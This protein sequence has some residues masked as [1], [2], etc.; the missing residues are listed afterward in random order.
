[1]SELTRL[2]NEVF[3]ENGN[4]KA[5]GRQSCISLIKYMQNYT[6]DNLG[7]QITGFMNVDAIKSNYEK[8]STSCV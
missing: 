8:L 4:V 5:C 1:M 3:D 6:A 7:D 2:Y